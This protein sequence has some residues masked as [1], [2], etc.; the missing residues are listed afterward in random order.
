MDRLLLAIPEVLTQHGGCCKEA[1]AYEAAVVVPIIDRLHA[2]EERI[3]HMV[4]VTLA[5]LTAQLTLAV[6]G[7]G[8]RDIAY[9]KSAE[10]RLPFSMLAGAERM[11]GEGMS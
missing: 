6:A 1:L 2:V 11:A 7:V 5:G 9:A 8:L 4:P 3:S 10:D